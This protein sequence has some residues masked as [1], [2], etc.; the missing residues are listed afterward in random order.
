MNIKLSY[1]YRDGA[2]HKNYHEVIFSNSKSIKC[3]YVEELIREVLI[4]GK[5]FYC[6]EWN[7]P[8]M[9]FKEIQIQ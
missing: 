5:W 4:D 3:N 8:D 2:N 1:L 9:H 7:L 6:K